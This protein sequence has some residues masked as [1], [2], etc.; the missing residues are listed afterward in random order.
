MKNKKQ[1][2]TLGNMIY[3][4]CNTWEWERSIIL[5]LFLQA[6]I[7]VCVPF[8]SIYMPSVI[9]SAVTGEIYV[10]TLL[11]FGGGLSLV[12]AVCSI[13]NEYIKAVNEMHL[14]NNKIHYLT[15]IFKKKM[16]LDY[17]IVESEYGQN[18]FQ[19]V[20]NILFNDNSGVSGML[21]LLGSFWGQ[22]LG[23]VLYIGIISMLSPWIV[24]FL[25][26]TSGVYILVLRRVNYYEYNH[27]E[28]WTSIDKKI[29]YMLKKTADFNYNKDIKLYAMRNWL[30]TIIESLIYDR[31]KWVT[32]IS[33]HN[34][35]TAIADVLLLLIRNGLAYL[36][37]F[38]AIFHG[39]IQIAEFV[40]YFGVITGFTD[41]IVSIAQ[42]IASF[43]RT[44]NEVSIIREYLDITSAHTGKV[45]LTLNQEET[46]EIEFRNVSF[47]YT[48]DSPF[49]LKNLNF[50][51][52]K[53]E[54]IAIV[55]ENGAG[56][57]TLVKLLCGFY[58]P[59]QGEIFLNGKAM[60][61]ISLDAIYRLYAVAF[62]SL[63][64]LPMSITQNVALSDETQIN[65]D[66]VR[67][68]LQISGLCNLSEDLDTQLTKMIDE[69]G[70]N[71][72]GG[73]TQKLMIARALYK[74]SPSLVLDEPTAALD[75]IAEKELYEAY[76]KLTKER[77]SI[78]I[79]HRLASTQF[80]DRILFLN[81]C[82][83][84]ESGTHRELLSN[85]GK[86][87]EL[88]EIQSQYYR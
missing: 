58:Q 15:I 14:T 80:C 12:F 11:I 18:K 51:I 71:L 54:K 67:S 29:N 35:I 48:E 23:F 17:Q 45:N 4:I 62:Q 79:S 44:G 25:L 34:F 70:I 78:F 33:H 19:D 37:I 7:G 20:M 28:Q 2:S 22:I 46:L 68:C 50:T 53:G 77:T 83:I 64:V 13:L 6:I 76:N 3:V 8:I 47:R 26:A 52:N 1:Y 61:E 30:T 24:L 69:N 39:E 75:P 88:Y 32:R 60:S 10:H 66:Y 82:C 72:S 43:A 57:T 40:L 86:Y 87:S 56:K 85:G 31:L 73:E 38:N 55:G 74:N 81:N 49:V 42:G 27:R 16:E 84:E 21:Q 41:F 65:L 59:T 9:L 36:Y 5:F 63:Y